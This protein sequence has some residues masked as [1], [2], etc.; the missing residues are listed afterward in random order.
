MATTKAQRKLF[1]NLRST[2]KRLGWMNQQE[3][4]EVA[5]VLGVPSKDVVEMEMRMNATDQAFDMNP[6]D[7]DDQKH[8]GPSQ[9]L[10]SDASSPELS[11]ESAQLE[12]LQNAALAQAITDLDSRSQDIIQRR[13]LNEKKATLTELAKQ[14]DISAERVRQIEQMAF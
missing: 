13:W 10:E 1:F 9:Y 11:L 8:F 5:E 6:A 14:Y 4:D 12:S 3:V 2:K 7:D